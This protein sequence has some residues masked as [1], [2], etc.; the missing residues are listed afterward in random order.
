MAA[1]AAAQGAAV[2]TP[3]GMTTGWTLDEVTHAY[4]GVS[5]EVQGGNVRFVPV[6][7]NARARYRVGFD[8]GGRVSALTLELA[9]QDCYA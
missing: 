5:S 9:A 2:H 7:G 4:Q 6:P 3:E 8:A 1:I